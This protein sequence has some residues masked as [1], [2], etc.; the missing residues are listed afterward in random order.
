MRVGVIS[1]PTTRHHKAVTID[2]ILTSLSKTEIL[3]E[4]IFKILKTLLEHPNADNTHLVDFPIDSSATPSLS[5]YVRSKLSLAPGES[6]IIINGRLIGPI[7]QFDA[8]AWSLLDTYEYSTRVEPIAKV[9]SEKI[10]DFKHTPQQ[11]LHTVSVAYTANWEYEAKA[12][13]TGSDIYRH[14]LRLSNFGNNANR[15]QVGDWDSEASFFRFFAVLDPLSNPAQK[16]ACILDSFS[17]V[18]GVAV[19]IRLAPK[20]D[21]TEMPLKRFY[22]YVL[23]HEPRFTDDGKLAR[24]TVLFR[25]VPTEPFL[26]M[27]MDG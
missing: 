1:N 12:G 14:D 25:N 27:G 21:L 22:R 24:P 16:W 15:I 17:R 19:E 10:K 23:D 2:T 6:A 3:D 26:T 11:L 5:E 4:D 20:V 18:L 8:E 7:D 13:F 9:F